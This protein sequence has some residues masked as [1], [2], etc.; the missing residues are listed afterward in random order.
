M[1]ARF[2]LTGARR[3]RGGGSV[4]ARARV[5]TRAHSRGARA[6]VDARLEDAR[7]TRRR[8]GTGVAARR[9]I[10]R[11]RKLETVRARGERHDIAPTCRIESHLCAW[12]CFL[13]SE[14]LTDS[15][16]LLVE[17]LHSI[18]KRFVSRRSLNFCSRDT[19]RPSSS[20]SRHS[21]RRSRVSS[22]SGLG[23]WRWDGWARRARGRARRPR[24]GARATTS[25]A[26][27]RDSDANHRVVACV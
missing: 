8:R 6:R 10:V 19:I 12:G 21:G 3:A 4:D 27:S 13:E 15:G 25:S 14:V 5:R 22:D 7:A 26:S 9:G 17:N 23:R 11:A 20:H 24:G 18:P 2:A 16:I 1:G